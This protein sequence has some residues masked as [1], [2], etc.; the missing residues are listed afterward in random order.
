[1]HTPFGDL[2]V[3][4]GV[5]ALWCPVRGGGLQPLVFRPDLRSAAT[6]PTRSA[7]QQRLEEIAADL[8]QTGQGAAAE[9]VLRDLDD[10]LTFYD[11]P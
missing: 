3:G 11:F 10:F 6:A 9:T 8:R 2:M 7:C 4:L 1:M 5:C